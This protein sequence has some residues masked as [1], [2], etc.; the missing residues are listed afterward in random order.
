MLRGGIEDGAGEFAV[1]G[2][3]A[4]VEVVRPAGEP[5]VVDDAD[6]GVDVDGS[7]RAVLEVEDADP[8]GGRPAQHRDRAELAEPARRPG[9]RAVG[10]RVAGH[11]HDHLEPR[12][13]ERGPWRCP[14]RP[15]STTGTGPR[16]RSTS[17]RGRRPSRRR[18][19]CCA[20]PSARRGT[21]AA[22]AR[23]SAGAARR[24]G[25]PGAVPAQ[26]RAAVSDA[27]ACREPLQQHPVRVAVVQRMRVVPAFGE[28]GQ[29]VSDH[30]ATQLQGG[31]VPRRPFAVARSPW[32][33]PA[34]L[35]R[36]R[37]RR[38]GCGTGR[39]RRRTRRLATGRPDGG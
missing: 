34:G 25:P 38:G 35:P 10:V 36:G 21:A 14:Q 9:E 22:S 6:L 39:S 15:R 17:A 29:Q 19:R 11:H 37:R 26:P 23:R 32:S 24:A 28:D 20:P 30:R 18:G 4:A 31:V 12:V 2:P 13:V 33:A 1:R 8:V 5:G 16:C 27:G 3:G 7:A